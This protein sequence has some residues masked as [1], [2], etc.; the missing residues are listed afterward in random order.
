MHVRPQLWV[1]GSRLPARLRRPANSPR[2]AYRFVVNRHFR[3][4]LLVHAERTP[5]INRKLDRIRCRQMHFAASLPPLTGETGWTIPASSTVTRTGAAR[6]PYAASKAAVD[7]L[8]GRWPR[9]L[10]AGAGDAA[11]R[12]G[13]TEAAPDIETHIDDLLECLIIQ[14]QARYRLTEAL[15][16]PA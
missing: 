14:R 16:E 9:T 2:A 12:R 6:H 13:G 11:R 3:Q 8:T 5:Q 15:P 4:T 10:S 7:G 1:D